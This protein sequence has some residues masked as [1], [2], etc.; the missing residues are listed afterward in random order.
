MGLASKLAAFAARLTSDSKV[1]QTALAANVAGNGPAFHYYQSTQQSGISPS[2]STKVN[3]QTA[4]YDTTGGMFSNSRFQPTIEG[5]YFISTAIQ[6]PNAGPNCSVSVAINRNG[7]EHFNGSS[8]PGTTILWAVSVA[9]G[10]VYLN[11][12]TDYVEVYTYGTNNGSSYSLYNQ[13]GRTYISGFLA[14]RA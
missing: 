9:S 14:R 12:T 1:P 7:N 10:L 8:N 5:W 6:S 4:V 3:F 11:G 13:I 2:V